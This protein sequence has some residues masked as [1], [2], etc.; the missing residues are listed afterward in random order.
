MHYRYACF[1]WRKI[2]LTK[3]FFKAS[4]IFAIISRKWKDHEFSDIYFCISYKRKEIVDTINITI[5]NYVETSLIFF[6]LI[7]GK[8]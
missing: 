5:T 4:I 8:F 2:V 3:S 6:K 7:K 1:P